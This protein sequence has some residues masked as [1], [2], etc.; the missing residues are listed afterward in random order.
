MRFA[1]GGR[2][3]EGFVEIG[4]RV[5]EIALGI[6]NARAMKPGGLFLGSKI[7][8]LGE[9][10]QCFGELPAGL[11]PHT[12]LKKLVSA[13]GIMFR[14]A[15]RREAQGENGGAQQRTT[16][17]HYRLKSS[18]ALVGQVVNLRPIVNRPVRFVHDR[19]ADY[20]S[21]PAFQAAL[22]L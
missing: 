10:L 7:D 6:A 5:L 18:L 15:W 3:L 14:G 22:Q 4:E 17:A 20:Q 9:G 2:K 21:A 16:L 13:L 1:V 19:Q 12:V 8:R 11:K